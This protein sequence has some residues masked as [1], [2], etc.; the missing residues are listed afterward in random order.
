MGRGSNGIMT[1]SITYWREKKA[2]FEEA[3]AAEYSMVEDDITP[4]DD[5]IRVLKLEISVCN[6]H[7][8]DIG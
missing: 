5:L 1:E 4:N 2:E 3:L 8:E 6:E 7:I